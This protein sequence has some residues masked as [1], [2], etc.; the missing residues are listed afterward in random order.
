MDVMRLRTMRRSTSSWLSPSPKR[1]PTPPPMRFE[2]RWAHMPRKRGSRYSFWASRTC[3]RPSLLVA[4]SAKMSRMSAVR[5]MTFTSLAHHL[6]E[7]RLLGGRQLVVEHH[8]VGRVGACQL[9]YL[10]GL[11]RADER[12]RVRRVELL[13][14]DGRN[15]G[16][17]RV[18]EALE[19]G[20]RRGQRPGGAGAVDAHEH[21]LLAALFG[22]R[23]HAPRDNGFEFRHGANLSRQ[24][25]AH[26]SD[27]G[28]RRQSGAVATARETRVLSA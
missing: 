6:L 3:S 5:S 10:L 11:A 1:D 8:E 28:V 2:A 12:A 27:G 16:A 4:C 17:R 20:E 23:G 15:V 22:Y 9:G 18:H 19:L 13:R 7:V 14:G 26:R 24:E 21:G 25:Q